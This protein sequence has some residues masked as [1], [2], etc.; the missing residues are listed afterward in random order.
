MAI[1][2]VN[3]TCSMQ[4]IGTS[5][6]KLCPERG[7]STQSQGKWAKHSNIN[8][9]MYYQSEA[10]CRDSTI[11]S[12]LSP[13]LT[14]CIYINQKSKTVTLSQAVSY[15]PSNSMLNHLQPNAMAVILLCLRLWSNSEALQADVPFKAVQ[16]S[17]LIALARDTH[18]ASSLCL[19]LGFNMP[20]RI[21]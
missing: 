1:L 18:S 19:K 13:L 10:W 4:F 12:S 17:Q 5:K 16:L 7:F 8:Q 2:L 21:T 9:S 20:M 15:R 3:K 11:F 14:P 6:Y